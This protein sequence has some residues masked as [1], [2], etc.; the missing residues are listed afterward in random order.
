MRERYG[1]TSP[2]EDKLL[3]PRASRGVFGLSGA[4]SCVPTVE[5]PENIWRIPA[6]TLLTL[7]GEGR[8]VDRVERFD[9][10]CRVGGIVVDSA[11]MSSGLVR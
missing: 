11:M 2:V 9:A 4:E 8:D 7:A 1:I 5:C 3:R 6:W 10:V